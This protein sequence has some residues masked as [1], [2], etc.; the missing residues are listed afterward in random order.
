MRS[1]DSVTARRAVRSRND[2]ATCDGAFPERRA[3]PTLWPRGGRAYP[4]GVR[5]GL[6]ILAGLIAGCQSAVRE[7]HAPK[8][9]AAA[10]AGV[11]AAA[12]ARDDSSQLL[13]IRWVTLPD[14][15]SPRP[16]YHLFAR[17]G[18]S[19][20]IDVVG[21]ARIDGDRLTFAIAGA[22]VDE[23]GD[24][25]AIATIERYVYRRV[26]DRAVLIRE[27]RLDADDS[28][29]GSLDGVL[30]KIADDVADPADDETPSALL[31]AR[32]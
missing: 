1:L 27:E 30:I 21:A 23:A 8:L 6:L 13:S 15:S 17:L 24:A 12:D 22:H 11:Y 5:L 25:H 3:W 28:S 2:R 32:E 29:R 16:I 18:A 9:D 26:R 14:E 19:A 4:P 31:I 20:R 10:W 7:A